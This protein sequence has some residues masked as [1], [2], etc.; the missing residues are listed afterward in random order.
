[1]E[2]P[3]RK[4][5]TSVLL[6]PYLWVAVLLASL[7]GAL[8]MLHR[9]FVEA[10]LPSDVPAQRHT[11]PAGSDTQFS[12]HAPGTEP[13]PDEATAQQSDSFW[14]NAQW[15]K[16]A[17]ILLLTSFFFLMYLL[18]LHSMAAFQVFDK[19]VEETFSSGFLAFL[20]L[21]TAY[22]ITPFNIIWRDF[23]AWSYLAFGVSYLLNVASHGAHL[24]HDWGRVT[25]AKKLVIVFWLGVDLASCLFFIVAWYQYYLRDD[26]TLTHPLGFGITAKDCIIAV[27]ALI[28]TMVR[29]LPGWLARDEIASYYQDLIEGSKANGVV[30]GGTFSLACA[31]LRTL[32]PLRV[33]DFGSA[34]S[35]RSLNLLLDIGALSGNEVDWVAHDILPTFEQAVMAQGHRVARIRFESS[36]HKAI[37]HARKADV[38]VVAHALYTADTTNAA[39]AFARALSPGSLVVVRGISP[40]SVFAAPFMLHATAPLRPA[41]AHLWNSTF[42]TTL[43]NAGGLKP[44]LTSTAKPGAGWNADAFVG[45][46]N[47]GYRAEEKV[48]GFIQSLRYMYGEETASVFLSQLEQLRALNSAVK[49]ASQLLPSIDLLYIFTKS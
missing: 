39:V 29:R 16:R 19:P 47:H 43:R 10:A 33:L 31:H 36:P 42:L 11:Q 4:V 30:G 20:V 25:N 24:R 13:A 2:T 5:R 27:S 12:T 7:F 8:G 1:M 18:Y 26:H 44:F 45:Y 6:R 32:R 15:S 23:Q 46:L 38:L 34:T 3:L 17:V 28:Y 40:A 14:L 9:G 41:T 49:P 48:S 37:E 21:L 22:C 35:Q